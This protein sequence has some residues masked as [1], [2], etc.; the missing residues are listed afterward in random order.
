MTSLESELAVVILFNKHMI[1]L[2]IYCKTT[3][4]IGLVLLFVFIFEWSHIMYVFL[5]IVIIA[6]YYSMKFCFKFM[7]HFR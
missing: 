4:A 1:V 3:T 7:Q 6:F 2:G 5:F